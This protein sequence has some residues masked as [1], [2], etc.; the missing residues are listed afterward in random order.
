MNTDLDLKIP[1]RSFLR[2]IV[3]GVVKWFHNEANPM[4]SRFIKVF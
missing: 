4:S 3:A 1:A 2:A